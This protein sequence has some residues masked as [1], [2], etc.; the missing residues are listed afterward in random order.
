[1]FVRCFRCGYLIEDTDS[2]FCVVLGSSDGRLLSDVVFTKRAKPGTLALHVNGDRRCI[3]KVSG[4]HF[5]LK[6]ALELSDDKD[7]DDLDFL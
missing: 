4:F 6:N 3:G 5:K 2:V 1:M 7:I